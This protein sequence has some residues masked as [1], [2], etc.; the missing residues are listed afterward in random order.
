MKNLVVLLL[1]SLM[2]T[3]AFA[4]IDPDDNMIGVYFDETADLNSAEAAPYV[5]FNAYIIITN[6]VS[7]TG[8]FAGVEYN[9]RV[10]PAGPIVNLTLMPDGVSFG[11]APG[12]VIMGLPAPIPAT[13]TITVA[14]LSIILLN[15]DPTG[16]FLGPSTVPSLPGGLPVYE[17]GGNLISL[18]V[19]TGHPDL[20]L[21]A[22]VVNST[23]VPVAIEETSFGSLKSL[24]R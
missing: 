12:D 3:S 10:E 17:D 1:V 18:G 13:E 23:E 14:S 9:W 11:S 15:T 16:I 6:P 20:G 21:P 22:A 24:F 2:A 5:A 19:S 8:T 7:A 4:T